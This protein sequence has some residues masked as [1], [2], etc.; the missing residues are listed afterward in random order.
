MKGFLVRRLIMAIPVLWGATALIFIIMNVLPGS[1]AEVILGGQGGEAGILTPWSKL[2]LEKE[3]GLDRPLY[4]QYLS[5]LGHALRGDMGVSLWTGKSVAS[6]VTNRLLMTVQLALLS[7]LIGALVGVPIGI[8]T[9]IK[10]DR[11]PD[12]TL[13]LMTIMLLA[14]PTFWMGLMVIL[15]GSRYFEWIP[16]IGRNLIWEHPGAAL[17]QLIWPA[18]AIGS[19]E[20][21]RNARMTRSSLLEVLRE[22]YIRT[23][24]SKGLREQVVYVRHAVRNS[25]IPVVTI[26]GLAFAGTLG[27]TVVL[28]QVFAI[29]GLGTLLINSI[30]VRDFIMVQ[31]IVFWY[32]I[33]FIVVNLA[34]D[35]VYGW[36]DPRISYR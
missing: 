15:I 1:I 30:Q 16:P 29:P 13:R 32:A 36:L 11:W 6:E 18:L 27:G 12:Y 21:A 22:D 5:W 31:G 17:I 4:L 3:L 23:A 10:Q 14:L 25:L 7:V 24:R 9:A 20:A 28:E 35:L 2:Q 33:I 8:I 34:T 19:H 26:I